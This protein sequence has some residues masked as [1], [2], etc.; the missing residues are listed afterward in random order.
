VYNIKR[1][2]GSTIS[3]WGVGPVFTALSV[4][5]GG[6]IL[7]LHMVFFRSL[8]F[9]L[10]YQSLNIIIGGALIVIGLPVFIV[11]AMTIDKYYFSNRLCTT[12]I[13]ACIRHP[14]YGAWITCIVPGTVILMGSILGIT[15]PVFMYAVYRRLIKKEENYLEMKFGSRY[16]EYKS[17]VGGIFPKVFK[18]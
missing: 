12:G 13:Y 14:I 10:G 11:P 7:V 5:Y 17:K 18:T 6:T 3:R 16:R 15:V 4:L 8:T 2:A 1:K 9:T